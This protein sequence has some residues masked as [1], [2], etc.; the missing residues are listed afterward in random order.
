MEEPQ[1]IQNMNPVPQ[2]S[3]P[4]PSPAPGWQEPKKPNRNMLFIALAAAAL[5]IA[6]LL[7]WAYI[8]KVDVMSYVKF[9]GS[10]S[11]QEAGQKAI[12]YINAN[13]MAGQGQTATLVGTSEE[14]GM[15]KIKIQIGTQT[16]DSYV[17]TDGKLLFPQA[18]KLSEN[19]AAVPA[20]NQ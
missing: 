4:T 17:T 16:F 13:G 5:I 3:T 7:L 6:G 1:P 14:S 11:S 12:D 18:I 15:V 2:P 9:G 8:A 10:L 19:P 20:Q